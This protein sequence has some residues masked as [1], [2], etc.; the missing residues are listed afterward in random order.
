MSCLSDRSEDPA[1]PNLQTLWRP[2]YSS[3]RD[4]ARPPREQSCGAGNPGRRS[5]FRS[6]SRKCS[7]FPRWFSSALRD[8]VVFRSYLSCT[9]TPLCGLGIECRDIQLYARTHGRAQSRALDIFSLG[10]RRLCLDNS[11]DEAVGIF[12]QLVGGETDLTHRRV[13][14]TRLI[15]AEL[16]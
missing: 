2:G 10:G 12:E 14:D 1:P 5:S 6:W 4:S 16:D 9:A 7:C 15:H 3:P 11:L 8:R 13:N